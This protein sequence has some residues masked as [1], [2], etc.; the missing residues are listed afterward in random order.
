MNRINLFLFCI[1]FLSSATAQ[2]NTVLS[3]DQPFF[4]QQ[5]RDYQRW[6]NQSGLGQVLH[7]ERVRVADTELS[8]D[9]GF[10]T[11]NAD[12][13]N[14]QWKELKATFARHDSSGHTL[15]EALFY[16]MLYFMEIKP[17]QGYVQLFNSFDTQKD[18]YPCFFRGIRFERG[19]VL[20]DEQ[21]CRTQ[22][23]EFDLKPADVQASRTVSVAVF[24]KKFSKSAVFKKLETFVD[25]RF[26]PK[27]CDN[28]NP[29]VEW[30]DRQDELWFNVNDLCKEVLWD[31]TNPWWCRA[32]YGAGFESYRNCI[33]RERLEIHIRYTE[34]TEG[35][36][37]RC[38]LDAKFGSGFWDEVGRGAYKNMET[39][40]K[41]FVE[42]YALKF[43]NELRQAILRP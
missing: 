40:Y 42:Q 36:N 38:S 9:L 19:Q 13:V 31:E 8:L 14:A 15:E 6:L 26:T 29:T 34:T 23:P 12:T 7:V 5:G 3:A 32:L 24:R 11:T 43:K 22:F 16:K 28:R 17:E 35:F 39:D 1:L 10:H 33:K 41:T 2:R 4:E 21:G 20:T 27:K 25:Q 30:L 37:I 18:L